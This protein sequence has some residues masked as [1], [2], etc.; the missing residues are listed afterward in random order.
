[1]SPLHPIATEEPTWTHVG[2]VPEGDIRPRSPLIRNACRPQGVRQGRRE[3]FGYSNRS[4][5][6]AGG[7]TRLK[8]KRACCR[9]PC[10]VYSP[11]LGERCRK[12]HVGEAGLRVR[13]DGPA[14]GIRRFFIASLLEMPQGDRAARHIAGRI[15]RAQAQCS[16]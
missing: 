8:R 1:M 2:F 9:G 16:L 5:P 15:E 13:L 10:F 4:A 6:A 3:R 14:G 12:K 11:E 7:K